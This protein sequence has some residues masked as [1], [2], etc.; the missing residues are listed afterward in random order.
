MMVKAIVALSGGMDSSTV[1]AEAIAAKRECHAVGFCYGSKH[2]R[3]ENHAAMQVARFFGVPF[4][5]VDLT[6]VGKHLRSNLLKSGPPI[7]EGHYEEETMRQ[8]VV[9]G[10][11]LLFIAV[12]AGMAESNQCAEVWL[13]IH[14]GDHFIY[15]DCRPD[16]FFP[17]RTAVT[18]AYHVDLI[19]PYLSGNKTSIIKRGMELGVPYDLTRTCYTDQRVACGRCGSCQER[20]D[21][22]K[23]NGIDDPLEYQTRELLP[24]K[25]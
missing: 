20:L 12:L 4:E 24:K 17:V 13:G 22:F 7:P 8:T 19:A 15:P 1:L 23:N 16:F 21:A 6:E 18:S 5:L 3:E 9:P 25:D 11:N 14:S 2:N 10:R